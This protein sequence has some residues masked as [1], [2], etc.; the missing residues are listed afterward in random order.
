S[1]VSQNCILLNGIIFQTSATTRRPADCKSAIQQ[2]ENL[3]YGPNR[4]TH[5][6]SAIAL[7]MVMIAI[8]VLSILVGGFAF[9]MKVETKLARNANY[10]TELLW[11]GRS[12]VEYCRYVLAEQMKCGQEPFTARNQVWAGGTSGPCS[13]NGNLVEIIARGPTI[14]LGNG[15][16]TWH[17]T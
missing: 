2:I 9:S 14:A 17:M 11:L 6:E 5:H 8:F 4:N 12:G 3:R 10:E 13:T 16:F 7:V 15:T 1:A